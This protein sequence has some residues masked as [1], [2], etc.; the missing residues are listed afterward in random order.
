MSVATAEMMTL[1]ETAIRPL[2]MLL[3]DDEAF[4]AL[5]ARLDEELGEI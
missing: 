3:L 2:D 5:A 1:V 4:R